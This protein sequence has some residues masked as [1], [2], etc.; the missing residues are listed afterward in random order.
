MWMSQ[1]HR[2]SLTVFKIASRSSPPLNFATSLSFQVLDNCLALLAFG[3]KLFPRVIEGFFI[4]FTFLYLLVSDMQ[5]MSLLRLLLNLCSS[6][7]LI[8]LE[9]ITPGAA[10]FTSKDLK[11]TAIS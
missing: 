7:C 11:V 9:S 2:K 5:I 3:F 10:T 1:F 8:Y 4:I 6:I